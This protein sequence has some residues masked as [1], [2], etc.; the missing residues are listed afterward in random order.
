MSVTPSP[1]AGTDN[2][3]TVCDQGAATSLFAALGGTPNAGGTWSGPSTVVG[4]MYDPATMNPG[5]YV[6][7]V[8]GT[9]PCGNASATVTVTETGSPNAGTNG[10][11]TVCSTGGAVNLFSSLGGTPDAGGTW[12]GGLVNGMFDPAVNT[13]GVYTYTLSA[14]P[15]CQSAQAG[16]TVTVVNAPG[17]GTDNSLT[18]CDQGAATSLFAALGGA[19]NAG[20][21]WS[22][23]STVV[24]GMY[25]PATMNP[26]AYVYTVTGAAPCGSA[27]ATVTVTETG[28]PNAG[29]NGAVTVCSTG[30]AVNLFSSLGGTP[31]A[32]GT[33][34]GGLVNGMFDPA[35][36]TAGVYTYTLSATP[37]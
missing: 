6:Y 27:S 18:V 10:A 25:D 7:T 15:P 13:A 1:G 11:V 14:T 34:S 33:W 26:G 37:P 23:P 32:G 20:G 36:N 30:G 5:A 17:A 22:G 2:S 19:P 21:T 29:T 4:G 9:A 24:G 3:L 8:T 16:V 31:D 28:S 12:S 35:V